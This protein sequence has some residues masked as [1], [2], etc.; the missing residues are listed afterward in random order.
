MVKCPLL[1]RMDSSRVV[2][3]VNNLSVQWWIDSTRSSLKALMG[4]GNF[5]RET[6]DFNVP[7][8]SKLSKGE[9]LKRSER[10]IDGQA[11]AINQPQTRIALNDTD[12]GHWRLAA[13]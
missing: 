2:V 6:P 13:C 11:L 5:E 1:K 7:C 8:R 12:A 3:K 9:V 4:V 10:A